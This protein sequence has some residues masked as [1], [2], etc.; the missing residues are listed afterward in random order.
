MRDPFDTPWNVGPLSRSPSSGNT[1]ITSATVPTKR[2]RRMQ[3]IAWDMLAVKRYDLSIVIPR[4][5]SQEQDEFWVAPETSPRSLCGLPD[6]LLMLPRDTNYLVDVF[7]EHAYF[8]YPIINRAMIEVYLMEPQSPQALFLLNLTFMAACKHLARTSDIKRAIQF[9]ERA[10]ELLFHIDGKLRLSRMQGVLLGSM[11]VYGVFTP[12]V[13]LAHMCGTHRAWPTISS[14]S[15]ATL[16]STAESILT[17]LSSSSSPTPP[18][19][20]SSVPIEEL[21]SF[22]DLQAESYAIQAKKGAIPDAVYQARLWVFWGFFVRDSIAR[23]YYGWPHGLDTMAVTAE[24][25]KIEGVVGLGG[26]APPRVHVSTSTWSAPSAVIGKRPPEKMKRDRER[27]DKIRLGRKHDG[28]TPTGHNHQLYRG[29]AEIFDDE[30]EEEE[31][32]EDD[33]GWSFNDE[34]D[35]LGFQDEEAADLDR[36]ETGKFRF[37]FGAE[38]DTQDPTPSSPSRSTQVGSRAP[39]VYSSLSK[40][41]LNQQSK[42]QHPAVPSSQNDPEYRI[43]MERMQDLIAAQDDTT[44][45]GERTPGATTAV[46]AVCPIAAIVSGD[47]SHGIAGGQWSEQAWIQDQELQV[48]QAELI[49]WE[50]ALPAHLRFC[51][52]VDQEDVNHKVNGKMGLL[53]MYYYT[54]TIMLQSAYLPI[55]QYLACAKATGSH[56]RSPSAKPESLDSKKPAQTPSSDRGKSPSTTGHSRQASDASVASA[57]TTATSTSTGTQTPQVTGAFLTAT[58][59]ALE[60][61]LTTSQ[62]PRAYVNT[63][64]RICSHLSNTILHH[65]ELLIDSYPNW[66]VFQ[67]KVNHSLCAAMRVCCLNAKLSTN[68]SAIRQEAKAGFKM[69]SDLF[70]RLALLPTPLTIRDWPAEEDLNLMREIEEEFRLLMTQEDDEE[71]EEDEEVVDGEEKEKEKG[72]EKEKEEKQNSATTAAT[73]PRVEETGDKD[74]HLSSSSCVIDPEVAATELEIRLLSD[75]MLPLPGMEEEKFTFEYASNS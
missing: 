24:L 45:S 48:L 42:G 31:E 34:E 18:E 55:Q 26:K 3:R 67:A 6:H 5:I 23:L 66:C 17:D 50:Q 20:L 9:R 43:H 65:C 70:K 19:R 41:I 10:R 60:E 16:A 58:A 49:A 69:G 2:S 52:Q 7:F 54:I 1:S 51:Q 56:S 25:P 46:S 57:S 63:A 12:V 15:T 8:Y 32:E 29:R 75:S 27:V 40:P 36:D 62:D 14:S 28:P 47:S 59:A 64:H 35:F 22:P 53:M 39:K 4:H 37:L 71:D 13:G 30:E 11:V 68:T 44:D 61:S 21:G 74:K 33:D 72:K 38:V 73:E